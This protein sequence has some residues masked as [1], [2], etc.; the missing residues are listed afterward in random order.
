M[1]HWPYFMSISNI[2]VKTVQKPGVVV[3]A[4]N[5]RTWEVEAGGLRVQSQSLLQSKSK[6][7]LGYLRSCLKNKA[8][9]YI[10]MESGR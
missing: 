4:S 10:W 1:Y 8:H 2:V 7:N 6:A 9:I 5:P 3:H